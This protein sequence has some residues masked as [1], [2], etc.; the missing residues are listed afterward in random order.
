MKKIFKRAA[1]LVC[2]MI[3][4]LG[5]ITM[6]L[7]E[8]ESGESTPTYKDATAHITKQLQMPE[9][10]DTPASTFYFTVTKVSLDGSTTNTEDM[11]D[12]TIATISFDAAAASDTDVVENGI[13]TVTGRSNLQFGEFKHAGVYVY[14]V[15]ENSNDSTPSNSE[16]GETYTNSSAEYNVTV[17]V[18][19]KDTTAGSTDTKVYISDIGVSKTKDDGGS[20]VTN[21]KIGINKS[22]QIDSTSDSNGS[23]NDEDNSG[24]SGSTNGGIGDGFLFVNQYTKAINS[25]LKVELQTTG[26]VA[27][28]T[29][30]FPVKIT[31]TKTALEDE[32]TTYSVVVKKNDGTEKKN[33][34]LTSGTEA[35][36]NLSN[37]EYFEVQGLL[38]GSK[39]SVTDANTDTNYEVSVALTNNNN[40]TDNNIT[41]PLESA[42]ST[43]EAETATVS[44]K[45]TQ[46]TTLTFTNSYGQELGTGI[47]INNLP[48][49]L[50]IVVALVG[51][52]YFAASRKRREQF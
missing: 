3:L 7:A 46:Q 34:T 14:T 27:D 19:N 37:G 9:L 18:A 4:V 39:F 2:S 41:L 13:K 28:R 23:G 22:G 29:K 25:P 26:N 16:T 5:S 49:L 33:T 45:L 24:E 35:T 12:L 40:N 50:L 21:G 30:E 17:Y 32:D 48:F 1:A 36:I 6:V 8:T 20:A 31:V 42:V 10:T 52:V 44:G 47:I 38:I 15:V 51:I 43:S 11:P